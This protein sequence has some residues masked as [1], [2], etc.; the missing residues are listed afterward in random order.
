M[1]LENFE[2]NNTIFEEIRN[3]IMMKI[4]SI[5]LSSLFIGVNPARYSLI[6]L[7]R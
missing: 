5:I 4:W 1:R 2:H 6:N 3:K 7:Q